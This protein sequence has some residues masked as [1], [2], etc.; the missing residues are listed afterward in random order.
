MFLL[1]LDLAG[2]HHL[3]LLRP[4]SGGPGQQRPDCFNAYGLVAK[5]SVECLCIG[6]LPR[7]SIGSRACMSSD[8]R[9]VLPEAFLVRMTSSSTGDLCNELIL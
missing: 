1:S 7:H 3:S 8:A 2:H 4:A 9:L 5:Y 6:G